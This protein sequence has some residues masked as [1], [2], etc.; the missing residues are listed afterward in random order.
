V[1]RDA[2]NLSTGTTDEETAV[3]GAFM[4]YVQ[5][6]AKVQ[7][8][9]TDADFYVGSDFVRLSRAVAKPL[10]K[11]CGENLSSTTIGKEGPNDDPL[12]VYLLTLSKK[13]DFA[14]MKKMLGNALAEIV[15]NALTSP[16]KDVFAR[17]SNEFF[18]TLRAS[19][20]VRDFILRVE[21]EIAARHRAGT[22]GDSAILI[23]VP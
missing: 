23:E 12:E 21:G 14:A 22:I 13:D 8:D 5:S 11:W 9:G 7:E 20:D 19:A 10:G 15:T 18:D 2:S 6:V 4:R 3:S 16:P 17:K 1:G